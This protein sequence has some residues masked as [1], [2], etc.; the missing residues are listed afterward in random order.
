MAKKNYRNARKKSG[1][2]SALTNR[3]RQAFYNMLETGVVPDDE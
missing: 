1:R 2:K 3:Q